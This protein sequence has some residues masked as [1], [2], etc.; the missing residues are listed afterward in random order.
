MSR[1]ERIAKGE[2]W[3]V[4]RDTETHRPLFEGSKSACAQY[5]RHKRLAPLLKLGR[6]RI[7]Q[8]TT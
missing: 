8:I 5:V 3:I 7:E 2:L 1:P 4:H 6:I